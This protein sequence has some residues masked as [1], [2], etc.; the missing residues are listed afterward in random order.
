MPVG[1]TPVE[2]HEVLPAGLA[3]R[4]AA[5]EAQAWPG[6]APGHDPALAPRAVLLLDAD[7]R[8][9]ASLAQ[10]SCDRELVPFYVAAGFEPLPGTVLVDGTP[11]DPPPDSVRDPLATDAPGL[12][13]TVLG[14]F[15][16]QG[17][18]PA[19]GEGADDEGRADEVRAAFTGIRVPLC[20]GT[21]DR[22]W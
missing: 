1:G 3:A 9:A 16:A 21:V 4:V 11:A 17:A 22:L 18:G 20:P 7:G 5:L 6:P 12:G 13:K 10:F 14:A 15:F 19:D 8:L 2:V